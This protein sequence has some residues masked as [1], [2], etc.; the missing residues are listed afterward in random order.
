[1]CEI[2]SIIRP[3]EPTAAGLTCM[4]LIGIDDLISI[5]YANEDWVIEDDIL[6][7]PYKYF[8]QIFFREQKA[9]L[10][11]ELADAVGGGFRKTIGLFIPRYGS[12]SNKWVYDMIGT[13]FIMLLQDYNHQTIL[14]GNLIAPMRMDK[15][16]GNTGQKLGDENGWSVNITAES[17]RPCYLYAGTII[18][19]KNVPPVIIDN[20]LVLNDLPQYLNTGNGEPLLYN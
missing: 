2:N 19:E 18:T 9:G 7:K 13:R 11:D 17:N 1:M 8:K 12:K 14:A 5:P 16:T 20:A 4:Y 3:C 15:A 10:A 6:L